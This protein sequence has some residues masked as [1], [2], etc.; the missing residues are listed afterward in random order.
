MKVAQALGRRGTHCASAVSSSLND[1]KA[2]PTST[3]NNVMLAGPEV[4]MKYY[5]TYWMI[6][7]DTQIGYYCIHSDHALLT[8][9]VYS[10]G[11][12]SQANENVLGRAGHFAYNALNNLD[13][14]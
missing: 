8:Y 7:D 11:D 10:E 9:R 3:V 13:V 6:A 2:Q 4:C 5:K 14:A 1:Q 12:I